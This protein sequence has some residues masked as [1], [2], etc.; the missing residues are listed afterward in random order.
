MHGKAS[1]TVT[2]AIA[3]VLHR[4][5][6]QP[7]I[8]LIPQFRQN[9]NRILVDISGFRIAKGWHGNANKWEIFI[10]AAGRSRM[11]QYKIGT[12]GVIE[13][14]VFLLK[15]KVAH[16]PSDYSNNTINL[17]NTNTW[18]GRCGQTVAYQVRQ[19][20]IGV[21]CFLMIM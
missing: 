10:V 6:R 20:E 17:S 14:R 21:E 11:Q 7:E 18:R 9:D 8:L 2:I 19:S 1:C 4:F 16:I 13:L 5:K 3:D 12:D 15:N